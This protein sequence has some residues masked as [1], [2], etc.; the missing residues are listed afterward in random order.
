MFKLAAEHKI[1]AESKMA[2]K[3]FLSILNFQNAIFQKKKPFCYNFFLKF[4]IGELF[5][6][7]FEMLL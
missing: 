1:A 6:K 7:F 2:A 3:T 4:Q 5:Y